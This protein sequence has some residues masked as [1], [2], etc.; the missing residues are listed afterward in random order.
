M[1]G[2]PVAG[3]GAHGVTR[4]TYKTT[5]SFLDS[6]SPLS[7][8]DLRSLTRSRHKRTDHKRKLTVFVRPILFASKTAATPAAA[9]ANY[10]DFSACRGKG[11]TECG[12]G[13]Y[14]SNCAAAA[15][16]RFVTVSC[17]DFKWQPATAGGRMI[18]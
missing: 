1:I 4:P 6:G 9:R 17:R 10:H 3:D 15:W 13:V 11:R 18:K 7:A 8:V 16:V 2:H 12:N 14:P 5:H